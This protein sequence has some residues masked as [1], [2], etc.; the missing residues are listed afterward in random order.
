M[1]AWGRIQVRTGVQLFSFP[2]VI[3]DEVIFLMHCAVSKSTEII[4]ELISYNFEA[5]LL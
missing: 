4:S 1:Q 5:K 3:L 2:W